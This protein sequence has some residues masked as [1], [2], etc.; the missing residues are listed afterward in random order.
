MWL[1]AVKDPPKAVSGLGVVV[2]RS[3]KRQSGAMPGL[4]DD[5]KR[6]LGSCELYTVLGVRSTAGEAEIRRGY[7]KTS[8][9]VHP[10]RV[11][12][13][14]KVEATLKF[15]VSQPRRPP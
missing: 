9:K 6:Y 3:V 2:E 15:Q 14:E 12:E 8:L 1:S 11:S 7:H 5:C 4:L 10:D 13:G